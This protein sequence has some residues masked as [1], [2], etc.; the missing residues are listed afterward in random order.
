MAHLNKLSPK[1]TFWLGKAHLAMAHYDEARVAF[2]RTLEID[3][4]ELR[5]R[6]GLGESLF[7]LGRLDQ[8]REILESVQQHLDPPG[9]RKIKSTIQRREGY[10]PAHVGLGKLYAAQSQD[11]QARNEFETAIR[12]DATY[13]EGLVAYGD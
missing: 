13:V 1:P 7:H 2:E 11:A 4:S 5:A 9:A 8:A 12:V 3:D 6:V 10:A